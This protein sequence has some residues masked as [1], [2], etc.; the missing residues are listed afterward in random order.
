MA[1]RETVRLPSKQERFA[2][3]LAVLI[4]GVGILLIG[5]AFIF[6]TPP[7]PNR[8]PPIATKV[9]E[10]P[11]LSESAT[12]IAKAD[13]PPEP[14]QTSIAEPEPIKQEEPV[15]VTASESSEPEPTEEV[16]PETQETTQADAAE[17]EQSET[18]VEPEQKEE[19]IAPETETAGATSPE[20]LELAQAD[21][22]EQPEI[23]VEPEQKEENTSA[24]PAPEP[25]LSVKGPSGWIYAGQFLDGQWL[26]RGLVIGDELPSSGRN[27]ALNWGANIRAT[28]PGKDTTLSKTI[29]Y[30]P[31]GRQIQIEEVRKSGKKGHIWLK[32]KL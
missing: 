20:P 28:P 14:V 19:K 21:V 7:Q 22:K 29:G 31:Q 6:R 27:Y 5:V 32:I 9:V 11:K 4:M 25:S 17:Q 13:T 26:E 2:R 3:G 10:T 23:K 18:T 12:A 24:E 15:T 1:N 16:P 8:L 30:L